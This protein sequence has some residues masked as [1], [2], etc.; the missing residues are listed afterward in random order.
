MRVFARVLL[1]TDIESMCF[2]FLSIFPIIIENEYRKPY[3]LHSCIMLCETHQGSF[4]FHKY[5]SIY[6]VQLL[7]AI[8]EI[9]H[10]VCV[11]ASIVELFALL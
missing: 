2:F 8:H 3:G 4:L 11:Y 6:S 5:Q 1:A 7:L 10:A 9:T